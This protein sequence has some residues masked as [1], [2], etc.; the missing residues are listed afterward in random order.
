MPADDQKMTTDDDQMEDPDERYVGNYDL[1]E[2]DN[3]SVVS[4][5]DG[6]DGA[7]NTG[8][9]AN[10]SETMVALLVIF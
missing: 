4:Q 3:D 5:N 8:P 9:I 2:T 1:S 6:L 7:L 10:V